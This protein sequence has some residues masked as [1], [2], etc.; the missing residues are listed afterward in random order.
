[1]K[2]K[3]FGVVLVA[4]LVLS[5]PAA[6][7]ADTTPPSITSVTKVPNVASINATDCALGPKTITIRANIWDQS[8]IKEKRLY[9]QAPGAADFTWV[10]MKWKN[11]NTFEATI[12]PFATPGTLNY[13]AWAKD[14]AGN[15]G[16][17]DPG[18][19]Q[20]VSCDTTPPVIGN[21]NWNPESLCDLVGPLP[22]T[23][24]IVIIEPAAP[25]IATVKVTDDAGAP[26]L[27]GSSGVAEVRI[28]FG[29]GPGPGFWT[30]KPLTPIGDDLYQIYMSGFPGLPGFHVTRGWIS[31]LDMWLTMWFEYCSGPGC[32]GSPELLYYIMALDNAGNKTTTPIQTFEGLCVFVQ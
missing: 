5:T 30:S 21:V 10:A 12:G 2:T 17:S 28:Y 27:A 9:Y 4:L 26:S 32:F 3:W 6:L 19:I 11:F 8:G 23:G 15:E 16:Q 25:L 24:V 14:K 22:F 31:Y 1:M 18:S 20:V 13:Y 29:A 7:A